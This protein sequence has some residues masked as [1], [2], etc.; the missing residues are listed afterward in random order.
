MYEFQIIVK[1]DD[2]DTRRVVYMVRRKLLIDHSFKSSS[3]DFP[4][5]Y[6]MK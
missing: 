4:S 6:S 3:S 5:S 1:V 2:S